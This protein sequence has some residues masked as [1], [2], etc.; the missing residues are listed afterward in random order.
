MRP[1]ICVD[2]RARGQRQERRACVDSA[3]LRRWGLVHLSARSLSSRSAPSRLF[4]PTPMDAL[5]MTASPPGAAGEDV[6]LTTAGLLAG[7]FVPYMPKQRLTCPSTVTHSGPTWTM[8]AANH[9]RWT[10]SHYAAGIFD[11]FVSGDPAHH[12]DKVV[13]CR[14]CALKSTTS[15]YLLRNGQSSN[16][17]KHFKNIASSR[18]SGDHSGAVVQTL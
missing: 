15:T 11:S 4:S 1:R 2:E 14:V 12:G 9:K 7:V 10:T 3:F 6:T 16:A 18:A 13:R 5:P 17:W 8:M